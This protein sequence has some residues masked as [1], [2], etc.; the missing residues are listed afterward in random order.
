M[1]YYD[2]LQ[3]NNQFG[4]WRSAPFAKRKGIGFHTTSLYFL[5]LLLLKFKCQDEIRALSGILLLNYEIKLKS[6]RQKYKW[7]NK[8]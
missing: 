5:K 4:E 1:M 6:L 7:K 3:F 2:G 8:A